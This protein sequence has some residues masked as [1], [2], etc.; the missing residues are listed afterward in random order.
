MDA[1]DEDGAKDDCRRIPMKVVLIKTGTRLYRWEVELI[2]GLEKTLDATVSVCT[3]PIG[4]LGRVAQ[5][6][7]AAEREF[8]PQPNDPLAFANQ[9]QNL[10]EFQRD[11]PDITAAAD[12]VVNLTD[13]PIPVALPV[14]VEIGSV[15]GVLECVT[16]AVFR[17]TD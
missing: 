9:S 10:P 13:H 2:R 3:I 11:R 5:A 7:Y 15:E 12:L 1:R 4:S 6:L 16:A 17:K 8:Y 14:V